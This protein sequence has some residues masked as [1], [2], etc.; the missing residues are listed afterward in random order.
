[1][2]TKQMYFNLLFLASRHS[3]ISRYDDSLLR[4]RNQPSKTLVSFSGSVSLNPLFPSSLNSSIIINNNTPT[5][6]ANYH[7]TYIKPST[8]ESYHKFLSDNVS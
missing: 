5:I 3:T 1:M 6:G 2:A 4:L 7:G 8:V